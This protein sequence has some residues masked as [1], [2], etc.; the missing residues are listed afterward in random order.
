MYIVI[1]GFG[2]LEMRYYYDNDDVVVVVAAAMMMMMM[3][4]MMLLLLLL[5]LSLLLLMACVAPYGRV[6]LTVILPIWMIK[7][8]K[9]RAK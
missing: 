3:M 7:A 8:A 4:M 2:A 6:L 1:E 5:S 9:P